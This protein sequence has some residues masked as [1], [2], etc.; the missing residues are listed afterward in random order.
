MDSE[1]PDVKPSQEVEYDFGN[2]AD[3]RDYCAE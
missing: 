3:L 1:R 2:S